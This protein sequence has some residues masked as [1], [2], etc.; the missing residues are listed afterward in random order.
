M[1]TVCGPRAAPLPTVFP[2]SAGA[3]LITSRAAP[4]PWWPEAQRS[5][6]NANQEFQQ[7]GIM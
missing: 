3:L 1:G 6:L 2:E 4:G 5:K 7:G